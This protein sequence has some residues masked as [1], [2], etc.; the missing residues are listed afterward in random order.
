MADGSN[1]K[2]VII[3]VDRF[4]RD[5]LFKPIMIYLYTDV[6]FNIYICIFANYIRGSCSLTLYVRLKR[7]KAAVQACNTKY[8]QRAGIYCDVRMNVVILQVPRVKLLSA[9][10]LRWLRLNPPEFR[11]IQNLERKWQRTRSTG[12][13]TKYENFFFVSFICLGVYL[14]KINWSTFLSFSPFIHTG[15][16]DSLCFFFQPALQIK[17]FGAI[18]NIEFSPVP[19]HNYA[20]TASTRVSPFI[21]IFLSL[22]IPTTLILTYS[23]IYLF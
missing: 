13:I 4:K 23:C 9:A 5:Y 22:H 1:V 19:P 14:S 7:N 18:T 21:V 20:V 2:L 11:P 3:S 12:K 10:Y 17:E 6:L 16:H 8:L 15:F